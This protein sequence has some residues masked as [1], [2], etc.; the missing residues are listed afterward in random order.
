M[1]KSPVSLIITAPT[2]SRCATSSAA[3]R[4]RVK[5]PGLQPVLQAVDL[6]HHG[7]DGTERL[8]GDH[9]PEDLLGEHPGAGRDRGEGDELVGVL[10]NELDQLVGQL[11]RDEDP[12]DQEQ[13]WP[14][15]PNAPSSTARAARPTSASGRTTT[16]PL[17]PSYITVFLAPAVAAIALPVE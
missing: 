13:S 9:R 16:V 7:V 12:L 11:T 4:S 15:L 14:A 8:H 5:T 1:P 3:S 6:G 2:R 10:D 17:P